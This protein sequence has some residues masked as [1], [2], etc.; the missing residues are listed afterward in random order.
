MCPSCSCCFKLADLSCQI[1]AYYDTQYHSQ[2]L[3]YYR[4][5]YRRQTAYSVSSCGNDIMRREATKPTISIVNL[6][7][8]LNI[9]V[10][11]LYNGDAMVKLA[12][13]MFGGTIANCQ[14]AKQ[15]F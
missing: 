1:A 3:Y 2:S 4:T 11:W 10:T 8:L 7:V 13:I 6:L 15:I 5:I 9:Q 14:N 12:I